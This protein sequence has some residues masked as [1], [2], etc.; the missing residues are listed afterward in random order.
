[1]TTVDEVVSRP[2]LF[3]TG[4]RDIVLAER[5]PSPEGRAEALAEFDDIPRD[6]AWYS[7]GRRVA[8][9]DDA[10]VVLFDDG[11]VEE[12]RVEG[13]EQV[14]TTLD[15]DVRQEL[16]DAINDRLKQGVVE[17]DVGDEKIEERLRDLG[18]F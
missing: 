10:K 1:G 4:D 8:I 2:T 3:D 5:G 14:P 17:E 18:Y 15:D 16:L 7:S 9:R 11:T 13:L 12:Y 6:L